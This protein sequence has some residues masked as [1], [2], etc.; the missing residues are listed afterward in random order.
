MDIINELE[1]AMASVE[2]NT[3]HKGYFYNVKDILII[4]ICGM[5][6]SLQNIEDIYE[7]SKAKPVKEMLCN[8]FG[9]TKIPC[10]AQFYNIIGCV[11]AD[12]FNTSF[13]EWVQLLLKDN[14]KNKTIAIDGKT[15]RSTD[16]FNNNIAEGALH[17]A[18]AY[19]SEYGL[20]IG[21]HSGTKKTSEIT[22]FRELINALDLE[23]CIIVSDA[24]HCNQKSANAVIEAK[25]DYIFMVKDNNPSLKENIELYIKNE[26]KLLETDYTLEQNG[27][28]IEK[29]TAYVCHNIDW[30]DNK[31]KWNSLSM[32]AGIHREVEKDGIKSSEWHYFISSVN[33][34][35]EELL[36]RVRKE[37]SVES[38]H[39]LL[40]VHFSE[41]K[42]R[43][44]NLN[45]QTNLNYIR[46][47]ALNLVKT[48][49][50]CTNSK[51][52]VSKILKRNLFDVNNL[53]T[54]VDT[55]QGAL[56]LD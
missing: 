19:L 43:V 47:T 18:S 22:A 1:K 35:A 29:R 44:W 11:K 52:A 6:C 40:D 36:S 2:E 41:D 45:L 23:S 38:M 17:I 49:K 46:K 55:L 24:L 7:W 37:W 8:V 27:G 51:L 13:M 33:F 21:S 16:K 34:S 10:R 53:I 25:A 14:M 56:K 42:T 28:R 48:F 3:A 50:I 26:Q 4:M 9:I 31:E 32:I 12:K 39:W 15:I 5:L 30:L 54:F 20:T